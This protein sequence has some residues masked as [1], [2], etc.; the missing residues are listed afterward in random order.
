MTAHNRTQHQLHVGYLKISLPVCI[1]VF[2][3]TLVFVKVLQES[4]RKNL[5]Q[6]ST[7]SA[8]FLNLIRSN[9]KVKLNCKFSETQHFSVVMVIS[10]SASLKNIQSIKSCSAVVSLT[11]V[12]R[13]PLRYSIIEMG[14]N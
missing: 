2:Q 5:A 1:E 12:S 13:A 8:I 10:A 14:A 6:F 4:E 3:S 11:R 9:A 7:K